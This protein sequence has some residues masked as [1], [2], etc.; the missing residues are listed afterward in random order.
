MTVLVYSVYSGSLSTCG[1]CIREKNSMR[2]AVFWRL[3]VRFS[4]FWNPL[5][6]SSKKKNQAICLAF[7]LKLAQDQDANS[8]SGA[9]KNEFTSLVLALFP[10]FKVRE[11]GGDSPLDSCSCHLLYRI[12]ATWQALRSCL[13]NFI[14]FVNSSRFRLWH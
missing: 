9:T 2:F 7:S 6:S 12:M 14:S 4:G 3:F 11:E 5:T 13:R 1:F 10:V 8:L